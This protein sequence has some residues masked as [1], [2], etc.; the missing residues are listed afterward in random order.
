MPS[1]VC[2]RLEVAAFLT[3]FM[4]QASA[5][6]AQSLRTWSHTGSVEHSDELCMPEAAVP[7]S[8]RMDVLDSGVSDA[9]SPRFG[10]PPP[11]Q[12]PPT[13][14]GTPL[15]SSQSPDAPP[16]GPPLISGIARAVRLTMSA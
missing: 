8:Y 11:F 5:E 1:K 3:M 6:A 2:H 10:I 14:A 15:P 4:F 12:A 16:T 9:N 7:S 13:Q